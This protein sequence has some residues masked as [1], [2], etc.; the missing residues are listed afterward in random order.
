MV[1]YNIHTNGPSSQMVIELINDGVYVD[2]NS[3]AY[4]EGDIK[5]DGSINDFMHKLKAHFI[6]KS[7]FKPILRGTGKIYLKA[8]LGSYHKFNLKDD[9]ELIVANNAFVACRTTIKLIPRLAI[10]LNSFLSGTPMINNQVKGNGN[11]VVKIP[12][13]VAE[14]NL[15][16]SKFTAHATDVAAYSP[17]LKVTREAAG[18]GWLSIAHKPV[19]VYRGNG[20]VYFI[21]HPNKGAKSLNS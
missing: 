7:Y 14:A 6:G 11:V 19:L 17:S 18:S 1:I 20:T 3:I 9:E 5:L 16:N 21:P 10:S 2:A 8:T 13:A 12:G 15:T 4:I